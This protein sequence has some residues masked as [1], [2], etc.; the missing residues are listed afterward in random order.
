MLLPPFD[1]QGRMLRGN[2]HGHCD[3]SDGVLSAQQVTAAY[4]RLG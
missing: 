3:H 2:L 4:R 1:H